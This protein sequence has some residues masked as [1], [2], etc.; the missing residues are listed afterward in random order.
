MHGTA[1]RNRNEGSNNSKG[2]KE[3]EKN[4]KTKSGVPWEYDTIAEIESEE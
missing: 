1:S 2:K 3:R 4:I